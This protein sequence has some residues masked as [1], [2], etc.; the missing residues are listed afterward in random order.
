MSDPEQPFDVALRGYSRAQVDAYLANV[1]GVLDEVEGRVRSLDEA[2]RALAQ[3]GRQ[4]DSA[5]TALGERVALILELARE[6]ADER[7]RRVDDDAQLIVEDARARAVA[8]R[9]EAES[10][11]EDLRAA[12]Q[13]A[14]DEAD[15]IRNGAR[16][17]ADALLQ[18]ARQRAEE[19]AERLVAQA[20]DEAR[21][22]LDAA[23]DSTQRQTEEWE[24]R[25]RDYETTIAGLEERHNRILRNLA[26]L[27]ASLDADPEIVAAAAHDGEPVDEPLE[28]EAAGATV[29]P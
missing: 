2:T 3:P 10:E 15:R 21:R 26:A 8:V 11:A 14:R 28:Q 24:T 23:T 6:E 4:D 29:A 16:Q 22:V 20:E 18:R 9:R 25:R 17:E 13:G 1:R 27:R 19:H 12:V 5:F 7:L